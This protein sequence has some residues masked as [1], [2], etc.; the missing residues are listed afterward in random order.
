MNVTPL[1]ADLPK[2]K[3]TGKKKILNND[4]K[5]HLEINKAHCKRSRKPI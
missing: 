5:F 3:L 4:M 2:F 1:A